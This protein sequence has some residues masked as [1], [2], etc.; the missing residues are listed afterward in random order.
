MN[1]YAQSATAY[2]TQRV[3]AASPEQQAALLMEAGQRFLG[4][5]IQAMAQK[6]HLE[7]ARCLGR[8]TDIINE[9]ILRLNQD[10]EG[11][12]VQNLQKIYH[13]WIREIIE[14]SNTRDVARLEVLSHHMGEIRQAWE[15]LHEKQGK[16]SQPAEFQVG[17]RVV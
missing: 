16:S 8:V 9:S 12:L 3:L 5:A 2:L 15:Q 6:A 17:D 13:W 14:A 1:A 10:D 7:A 11:E 4:K